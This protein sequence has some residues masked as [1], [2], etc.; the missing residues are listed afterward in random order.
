M[1]P[2]K[3]ALS[4]KRYSLSQRISEVRPGQ[5]M[6]E[7]EGNDGE[8]LICTKVVCSC[9]II[10]LCDEYSWISW[11]ILTHECKSRTYIKITTRLYAFYGNKLVTHEMTFQQTSKHLIIYEH[12]ID[13][14][15]KSNIVV[16][17]NIYNRLDYAYKMLPKLRPGEKHGP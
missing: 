16:I 1:Y 9:G 5:N 6:I 15:N 3:Q 17:N 7:K 8:S 13:S 14:E 11:I 10:I 2:Q 12:L 4:I